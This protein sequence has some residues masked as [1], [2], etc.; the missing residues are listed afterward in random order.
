MRPDL[1]RRSVN[2]DEALTVRHERTPVWRPLNDVAINR[3]RPRLAALGQDN[4]TGGL[5]QGA[6]PVRQEVGDP[7]SFATPLWVPSFDAEEAARSCP[8]IHHDEVV[9][10]PR[11]DQLRPVR[12]KEL[13]D[14]PRDLSLR[15]ATPLEKP[16]REFRVAPRKRYGLD[17]ADTECVRPNEGVIAA[18][19]AE[20]VR[21]DARESD[22]WRG[23]DHRR[24][25]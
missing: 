13:P 4:T 12:I 8:Q 15:P 10:R 24:R 18:E 17:L 14:L 9:L 23:G 21:F 3:E 7:A 20:R 25:R 2:H 6:M 11:D 22:R 5:R 16:H 19:F 1:K